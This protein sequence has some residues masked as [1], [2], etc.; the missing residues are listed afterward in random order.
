MSTGCNSIYFSTMEKL[1]YAKRDL[2][3]SRVKAARGS[4]EAAK[5]QFQS[6]LQHFG[7]VVRYDGGSLEK[8]YDELSSELERSEEKAKAV[9]ARIDAVDDVSKALFR[10]WKGELSQYENDRLRASSEE[11]LE[12][13]KSRYEQLIR[14]M[15]KAEAK[16]KPVLQPLRDNV[17]FLKHNLNAKAVASLDAEL[18]TVEGNVDSLIRDLERS[19]S[20]AD[21]FIQQLD[22]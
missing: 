12:Q 4:Q 6:A 16:M 15:R 22:S 21:Q 3:V 13:T 20:E 11:K 14:A 10:E 7:A 2:M 19:I 18:V 9:S 5:E 17:L 1:G 8:K